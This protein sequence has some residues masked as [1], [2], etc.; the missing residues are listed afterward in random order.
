MK[1]VQEANKAAGDDGK[2]SDEPSPDDPD[3]P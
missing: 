3:E 2:S 1:E